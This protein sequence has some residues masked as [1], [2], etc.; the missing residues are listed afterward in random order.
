VLGDSWPSD[1]ERDI[2]YSLGDRSRPTKISPVAAL[3]KI[4]DIANIKNDEGIINHA[5]RIM[6]DKQL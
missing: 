5:I 6:D 1:I 3:G 2:E 4:L